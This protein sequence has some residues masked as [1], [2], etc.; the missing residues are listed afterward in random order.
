MRGFVIGIVFTLVLLCLGGFIF[1]SRGYMSISADAQPG[2]LETYLATR[3]LDA[4]IERHAMKSSN[5]VP[6]TD[7]NLSAGMIGYTMNCAGCHGSLDRKES[8]LGSAFYPPAPN[9]AT[10]ALGDPQWQ[11]YYV[12]KN[13]IRYTGM[14]AWGKVLDDET[15]WK[16]TSFLSR[17]DDLPPAVKQQ[18]PARAPK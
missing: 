11:T 1:T 14:P 2:M 16:I 5:P 4:S 17:L 15:I 3:A 9:L 8:K 18:M 12:I 6:E 13:G 7:D 10:D